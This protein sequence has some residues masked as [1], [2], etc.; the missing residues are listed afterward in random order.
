MIKSICRT[1]LA[2]GAIAGC[3]AS[4]VNRIAAEETARAAVAGDLSQVLSWLPADTETIAVARGPFALSTSPGQD[5]TPNRVVSDQNLSQYFE[6]LPLGLFNFKG[7]LLP[8]RLKG[9]RIVLA[10]EG[11]RHFRAPAGLGEMPFEG[12][13]IAVFADDLDDNVTSFVRETRKEGGQ[14]EEIQGQ[15]VAVFQEKL[16][17]DTWTTFVAFPNKRIAVVATDRDYVREVL[18]RMQSNKGERALPG[19]LPEWKYIDIQS[20][21]WGLRH[22]DKNQAKTDPSSPFGGDKSA[23]F[24]DEHAIGLAF[25]FDPSRGRSAT[26]TY[27]SGDKSITAKADASLLAMGQAR[28]AKGLDIRYRELAPGVV[29]G[30]YALERMEPIQFFLFVLEG[31]LG[32][33]IY[34]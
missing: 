29:Q 30:S 23:N 11:S 24:P 20:R 17:N 19:D 28:E 31:M 5:E 8:Q 3:S 33:G 2:V 26:I 6:D 13:A 21:F 7:G 15:E 9:K 27:L 12:A 22:F 4:G 34:L 25:A 16:E 1:L 14:V 18:T 32:H 10:L